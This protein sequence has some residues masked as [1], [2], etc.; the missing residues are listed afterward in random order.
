VPSLIVNAD[1]FGLTPGVNRAIAELHDAGCLT[2]ATLMAAGPAFDDAV[3]LAHARPRLAVGCHV[4]LTDGLPILPAREIPS[5]C[6]DGS[7]FRPTLGAF[8][9]DLMLGRL[10][11]DEIER[12]TT[13]QIRR[14]QSAGLTVTHVDTHKHTHLFPAIVRPIAR[15]AHACGVR[16]LRNPFE[17]AWSAR[18]GG[19]IRS[20][21]LR[22]L[23]RLIAPFFAQLPDGEFAL[24]HGTLGISATG[25]LN[26]VSLDRL[27]IAL[28]SFDDTPDAVFELV[29]HPGYND[30]AL[31]RVRTRLRAHRQTELRALLEVIPRALRNQPALRLIS[32]SELV[33][34]EGLYAS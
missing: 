22:A 21:Q 33:A 7:H 14:L 25:Q 26:A 30:A 18:L 8:I 13:A 23:H 29:C 9:R 5:L 10:H 27:L 31:D 2:S 20:L 32:Y 6:P 3:A 15:A 12:E 24:P 17:P 28:C 11:E 1:D 16:R 4:V 34:P 19:P